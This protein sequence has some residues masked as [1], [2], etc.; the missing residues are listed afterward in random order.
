MAELEVRIDELVLVGFR[1]GQRQ[2]IADSVR[3]ELEGL[4]EA[5]GVPTPLASG[6]PPDAAGRGFGR[7]DAGSLDL[8]HDAAPEAVGA[9][10]ARAI[11]RSLGGGEVSGGRLGGG[12]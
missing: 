2:A 9:Q 4:F 12:R 7:V 6:R 5:G 3:R 10:M 11:H 1:S 8:P